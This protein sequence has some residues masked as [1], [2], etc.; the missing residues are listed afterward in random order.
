MPDKLKEIFVSLGLHSNRRSLKTIPSLVGDLQA[1]QNKIKAADLANGRLLS[2]SEEEGG[3]SSEGEEWSSKPAEK[4][5]VKEETTPNNKAP[6]KRGRKPKVEN[7][8]D[9]SS[10]AGKAAGKK[11]KGKVKLENGV[12]NGRVEKKSSKPTEKKKV[13]KVLKKLKPDK[14]DTSV[15]K[16]VNR[17]PKD[18]NDVLKANSL[19][20]ESDRVSKNVKN[21]GCRRLATKAAA[22]V[23][24]A[25][26]LKKPTASTVRVNNSKD[27]KASVPENNGKP[28]S[29]TT[30]KEV[31][32]VAKR[33]RPPKAK[34]IPDPKGN[35]KPKL[36]GQ[37][38]SD[39]TSR[40]TKNIHSATR[41]S[42][43]LTSVLAKK[44]AV[45]KEKAQSQGK[46][47]K[48][49]NGKV[50]AIS[51]KLDKGSSAA[52]GKNKLIKGNPVAGRN[53]RVVKGNSA[54]GRNRAV[55]EKSSSDGK[56]VS[57][58]ART[59]GAVTVTRGSLR[60]RK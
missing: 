24:K 12:K 50:S 53:N 19:N 33:G 40:L 34:Q 10:A 5:P 8:Q 9:E 39:K 44:K 60:V 17:K 20:G 21:A 57:L 4:V 14:A 2:T 29:P 23:K 6:K 35:Q 27:K 51:N 22:L 41:K 25:V 59:K 52:N 31:K 16:P 18:N 38:I 47:I 30:V 43:A 37:K 13:A 55:Q 46:N 54:A 49:P 15:L 48:L 7:E 42:A 45:S 3:M 56:K 28:K 11:E 1:M 32:V 58:G 26:T 36:N